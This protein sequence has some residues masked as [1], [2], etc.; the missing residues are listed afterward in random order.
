MGPDGR[1][2]AETGPKPPLTIQIRS[3]RHPVSTEFLLLVLMVI[4]ILQLTN[5]I[6][7]NRAE[8][9]GKPGKT[10]AELEIIATQQS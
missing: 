2:P 10:F 5:Q 7:A 6:A 8:L 3:G 9:D 1:T 4:R